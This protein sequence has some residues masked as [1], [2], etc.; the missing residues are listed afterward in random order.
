MEANFSANFFGAL[1]MIQAVLPIMRRQQAGHIINVSSIF[2]T[3]G[4]PGLGVYAATKSALETA[5][6]ALAVE[7]APWNIKI[8]N[9]Q[10][11]LVATD[12]SRVYGDR[13]KDSGDPY[14][15]WLEHCYAW[16]R[17]KGPKLESAEAVGR[18]LAE[19]VED[20]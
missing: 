13:L 17:Q 14:A 5:S 8:T 15:G 4:L 2:C 18:A 7:V 16:V 10:P 12:L 1:R 6:E 19:I 20:P 9:Y 3:Y 11:G